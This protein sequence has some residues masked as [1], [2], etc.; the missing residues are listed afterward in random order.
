MQAGRLEEFL[1]YVHRVPERAPPQRLVLEERGCVFLRVPCVE[2]H[3]S[4]FGGPLRDTPMSSCRST[5]PR[6]GLFQVSPEMRDRHFVF[7]GRIRGFVSLAAITVENNKERRR[8]HGT[9]FSFEHLLP[10][11]KPATDTTPVL[12]QTVLG[13]SG[14]AG[15]SFASENNSSCAK[16]PLCAFWAPLQNCA[17]DLLDRGV[18][19]VSFPECLNK[20]V[21]SG[22]QQMYT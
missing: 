20:R 13:G 1:A 8:A 7:R 5:C 19:A 14:F 17:G 12:S 16:V 9:G 18:V 10:E 6:H 15:C 2:A 4:H 3:Q 11:G 22:T 21:G